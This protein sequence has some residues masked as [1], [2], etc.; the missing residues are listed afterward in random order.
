MS[1][2]LLGKGNIFAD[3]NSAERKKLEFVTHKLVVHVNLVISIMVFSL[4]SCVF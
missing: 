1:V 3:R 4:E 2:Q